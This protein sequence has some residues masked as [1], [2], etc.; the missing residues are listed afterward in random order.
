MSTVSP[1]LAEIIAARKLP[2]PLS[3]QL[4]TEIVFASTAGDATAI[5]TAMQAASGF[6][7]MRVMVSMGCSIR[8]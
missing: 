2:M 1:L 5:A 3:L 6:L 4:D 8:G 7:R